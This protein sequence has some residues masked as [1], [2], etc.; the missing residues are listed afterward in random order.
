MQ[1]PDTKPKINKTKKSLLFTE[2]IFFV[3]L[4]AQ[5]CFL[6]AHVVFAE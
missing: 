4:S 3:E 1:L 2:A 6:N 5:Q